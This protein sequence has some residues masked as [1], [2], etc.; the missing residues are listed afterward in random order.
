MTPAIKQHEDIYH[1][2]EDDKSYI[3]RNFWNLI[4]FALIITVSTSLS[5]LL[6]YFLVG[7]SL[8]TKKISTVL[9]TIVC[10]ALILLI[11]I[12]LNI[13]INP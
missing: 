9:F 12:S 5:T 1:K 3:V 11:T 8:K 7:K 6:D 2:K 10:I 4:L 13:E